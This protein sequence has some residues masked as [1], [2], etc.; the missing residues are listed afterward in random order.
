MSRIRNAPLP[1]ERGLDFSQGVKAAIPPMARLPPLWEAPV[2]FVLSSLEKAGMPIAKRRFDAD[3]SERAERHAGTVAP[4]MMLRRLMTGRIGWHP[5]ESAIS[6]EVNFRALQTD[7]VW[8]LELARKRRVFSAPLCQAVLREGA[9]E[10]AIR[11]L[12]TASEMR[13]S[14]HRNASLRDLPSAI[15]LR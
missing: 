10:S 15:F 3:R 1:Y 12:K 14:R 11:L 2:A 6:A 5:F 7:R 13:L 8:E 9:H 4:F